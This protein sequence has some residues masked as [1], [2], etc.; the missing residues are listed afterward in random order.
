MT[1]R[2]ALTTRKIRSRAQLE[3]A[4]VEYV[5]WFNPARLHSALD[6][7][8]PAEVETALSTT[9]GLETEQDLMETTK[10]N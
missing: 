7:R 5:G 6:D 4:I 8:P 2:T 9:P 1:R 3:L 10:T